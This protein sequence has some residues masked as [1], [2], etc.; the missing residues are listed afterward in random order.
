MRHTSETDWKRTLRATLSHPDVGHVGEGKLTFG[1]GCAATFSFEG[2]APKIPPT[3]PQLAEGLVAEA[4]DGTKWSLFGC[5]GHGHALLIDFVAEHGMQAARIQRFEVRYSDVSD[6]FFPQMRIHDDL[7]VKLAWESMP[8]KL[9]AEVSQPDLN[10]TCESH[11]DAFFVQRGEDRILHQHFEFHFTATQAR[12]TLVDVRSIAHKFSQLLSLL[13]AYPCS[14]VSIDV[15]PDGMY[16]GRLYYGISKSPTPPAQTTNDPS[17][18]GWRAFF[19][20]KDDVDGRWDGVVKKFFESKHRDVVWARLAG[21]QN[22]EGFWEY[23]IFGYVALLDGYVSMAVKKGASVGPAKKRLKRLETALKTISP[24][25]MPL[26]VAGVV[27]AVVTVFSSKDSFES[28]FDEF[29]ATLD[30]DV[31]RII[32]FKARDFEK[33]KE[34]RNQVA[35]ALEIS[36]Q[37][38]DPTSMLSIMHRLVLLLTYLFFLDVGL[39]T[40][41]FL[42]SLDRTRSELRLRADIDKVHL[43]RKLR[44]D[45]FFVVSP[46]AL[47]VIKAR[48]RRLFWPCFVVDEKDGIS[49]SPDY[50]QRLQEAGNAKPGG[51]AYEH[52][53]LP[54]Q[55]VRY[56]SEAYFEDGARTESVHSVVMINRS[57]LPT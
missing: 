49:Y 56:L 17:Y 23:R 25:L 20:S 38:S 43:D 26:Q 41:I 47:D 50:S 55:A 14:I 36:Y 42:R 44:P 19:M 51:H 54:S 24:I 40:D 22:F 12:F 7:G 18:V 45:T 34:L 27:D 1:Y 5:K 9:A 46:G 2:F 6:W 31:I 37:C 57:M 16:G 21:M 15:S 35:H 33:I 48:S 13:L 39:G 30:K 10:F 8:A 4:E 29:V 11:Y 28:K 3:P 52:L 32:N 53:G